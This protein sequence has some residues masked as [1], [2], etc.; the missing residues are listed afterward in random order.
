MFTC[1]DFLGTGV[2]REFDVEDGCMPIQISDVVETTLRF[3]KP[4][5]RGE[6]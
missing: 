4:V 5:V 6:Q 3:Y 2:C 1:R